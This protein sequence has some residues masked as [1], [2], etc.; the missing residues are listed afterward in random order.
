MIQ[1]IHRLNVN[2]IKI[3]EGN[4]KFLEGLYENGIVQEKSIIKYNPPYDE[5]VK[6]CQN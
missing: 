4:K 1:E 3:T 6:N 2:D 5:R